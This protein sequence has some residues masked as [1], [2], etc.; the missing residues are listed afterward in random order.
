MRESSFTWNRV[1]FPSFPWWRPVWRNCFP[2]LKENNCPPEPIRTIFV[3]T[4][5]IGTWDGAA[6]S[7]HLRR[8]HLPIYLSS[9][10]LSKSEANDKEN[11]REIIKTSRSCSRTKLFRSN[12]L[13]DFSFCESAVSCGSGRCS[14]NCSDDDFMNV[15]CVSCFVPNRCFTFAI[16]AADKIPSSVPMAPSS[17]SNY[18][19]AIGGTMSSAPPPASTTSSTATC[20]R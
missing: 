4:F 3:A 12:L 10:T 6:G 11:N 13:V 17:A 15:L 20:L 14:L 18:L 19:L 9:P 7:D 1:D 5:S 8:Q 16:W 2:F